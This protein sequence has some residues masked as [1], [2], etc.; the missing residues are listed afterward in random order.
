MLLGPADGE[1]R[2]TSKGRNCRL[3]SFGDASSQSNQCAIFVPLIGGGSG[4]GGKQF[5][6]DGNS[7]CFGGEA[8]SEARG[9]VL[10]EPS[11]ILRWI[12]SENSTKYYWPNVPQ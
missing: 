8:I 7:R 3:P 2:R 5:A 10:G 12:K 1:Q 11:V 9:S 6:L 4:S